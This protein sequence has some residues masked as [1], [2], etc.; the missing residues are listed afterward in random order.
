MQIIGITLVSN[1]DVFVDL[2]IRNVL[3]FCDRIIIADHKSTDRTSDIVRELSARF[4]K[5]EYHR[6]EYP[7]E[8]HQ[9][10]ESFANTQ[11]WVFG[12]DGD[13]IYDPKGLELLR[14]ALLGGRY[15]RWWKLYGN[16][17]NCVELDSNKKIA[18]GYLSPPCRS[19]TKL[20]NFNAIESW[21]G[22]CPERLH[23]GEIVYKKNYNENTSLSLH[24]QMTW[25]D[26]MFRCLH[27]CFLKRSHEDPEYGG[28]HVR[29]NLMDKKHRGWL[30]RVI[31]AF[32]VVQKAQAV[33]AW[34]RDKYMRGDLV[35][36]NISD[37]LEASFVAGL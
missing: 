1:E 17:L 4:P 8:S 12:V 5:I 33:S 37:F 35:E 27:V 21:T 11:S 19:M 34:K 22:L 9:L 3:D 30:R 24:E 25:E 28:L 36:K 2:A 7:E 6:I 18:R 16:V 15:D 26:S 32:S 20:Y 13:E 10:I 23:D 29:R 14:Q 31:E